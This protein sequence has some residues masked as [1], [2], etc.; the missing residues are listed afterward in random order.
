[1]GIC[2]Y[3]GASTVTTAGSRALKLVTSAAAVT[4]GSRATAAACTLANVGPSVPVRLIKSSGD[5][6]Q[7]T[8]AGYAASVRRAPAATA[9]TRPPTSPAINAKTSQERQRLRSSSRKNIHTA[10]MPVDH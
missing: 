2:P 8:R 7:A 9:V 5:L 1:V 6:L 10:V 4:W 3:A